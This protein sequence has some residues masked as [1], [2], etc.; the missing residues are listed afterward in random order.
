MTG[1]FDDPVKAEIWAMVRALND[2]WTIGDPDELARYFHPD[3]VAITATDR[4]RREG[5]DA[6][7]SG[8][9]GFARSA[10]MH[11]W[12]ETDPLIHVH[13]DSAV[14]AYYFDMSFEMGGDMVH[15]QGRDMFFLAKLDGRWWVVADQ[16]SNYPA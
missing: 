11:H 14:V 6:C 12:K 16:F 4:L 2:A 1:R 13:G 5:A 10:R 9:K 15:S 3:M 8:W 7:I